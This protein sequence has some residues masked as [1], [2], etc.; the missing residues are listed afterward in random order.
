MI[1]DASLLDEFRA[2]GAVLTGHFL[3][4]S[5]L[6]SDT[7]VQCAKILERPE[8]SERLCRALAAK[9]TAAEPDVVAGPAYG[10]IL[11]AYELARHLKARAIF[12]E[13]VDGKFELRRGF[14]IAKGDRVLV[15]EDVVTTGG[16]AAEVVERVKALGGEVVGVA[17]FIDRGVGKAFQEDLRALLSLSPPVWMAEECPLCRQGHT[18]VKPGSRPGA[19]P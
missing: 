19:K 18:I 15:A 16:S 11:V 8:V 17:A 13:R 5:G 10:G 12:F 6:H 2:A 4:S 9:W 14:E 7:Y 1:T 3:L